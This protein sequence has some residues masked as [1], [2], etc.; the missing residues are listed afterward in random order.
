MDVYNDFQNIVRSENVSE[1]IDKYHLRKG[2]ECLDFPTKK[3]MDDFLS[4]L[5]VL[6]LCRRESYQWIVKFAKILS[7]LSVAQCA[8]F[9]HVIGGGALIEYAISEGIS[10]QAAQQMWCR[11]VRKNPELKDIKRRRFKDDARRPLE[12][13]L[14]ECPCSTE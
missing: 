6:K 14:G 13:D 10:E 1:V 8:L 3:A 2:R 4:V 12:R 11:I 5:D 9:I 7:S